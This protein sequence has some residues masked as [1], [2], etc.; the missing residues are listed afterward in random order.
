MEAWC[1][2]RFQP[3]AINILFTCAAESHHASTTVLLLSFLVK[4]S[5]SL[6]VYSWSTGWVGWWRGG[7]NIIVCVCVPGAGKEK[8]W[9]VTS[10]QSDEISWPEK[11]SVHV[12]PRTLPGLLSSFSSLFFAREQVGNNCCCTWIAALF[13]IF[14]IT[15]V[16]L[17]CS[18]PVIV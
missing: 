13:F 7:Y 6:A 18:R 12:S 9:L 5:S 10:T 3:E 4:V 15:V 2:S 11:L 14:I 8:R 17:C 16:D 1:W